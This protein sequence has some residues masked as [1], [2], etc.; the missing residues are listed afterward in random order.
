MKRLFV[1]LSALVGI[2]AAVYLAG[3]I[4]AQ[5]PAVG[6]PPTASKPSGRVAV[7]NVAKVMRDYSRWQHFAKVMN[8]KRT[9][10]SGELVK[11]NDQITQ[12]Q[13][14]I[15]IEKVQI[16]QE[17]MAKQLVE[18]QRQLE[19]KQRNYR[20]QLDEE[21]AGYLRNLFAEIQSCVKA[22]VEANGFDLVMAY[23]DA[24]TAEELNSPLYY[25]LKLRPPAAMPFY[26]SPSADM[27][28]VLIATLNKSFPVPAVTQASGTV[29]APTGGAVVPTPG[30]PKP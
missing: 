3:Q 19:D 15:Q 28:D 25:D 29:P 26:V 1:Y 14:K 11:L 13:A 22:V 4:Q 8:D 6:A 30:T 9:M 21:S 27:T 24:I 10:A 17:V 16:Q 5:A 7:F 23:P 20:K 2:G 18:L 12:T